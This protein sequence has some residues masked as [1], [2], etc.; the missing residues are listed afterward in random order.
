MTGGHELL[1]GG[2]EEDIFVD[3]QLPGAALLEVDALRAAEALEL[4]GLDDDAA[5]LALLGSS[6]ET[7]SL[8]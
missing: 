1:L 6:A 3:F 7:L 5:D 2:G 8:R 4:V